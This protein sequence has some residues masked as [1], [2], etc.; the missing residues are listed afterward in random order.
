MSNIPP[1]YRKWLNALLSDQ[2][3]QIVTA[4]TQLPEKQIDAE[5]I[6]SIVLVW[7]LYEEEA[8][9]NQAIGLLQDYLDSSSIEKLPHHFEL[10][11]SVSEKLP[12]TVEDSTNLQQHHF[13]Q[14]MLIVKD[15]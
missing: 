9:Q 3:K 4:L 12:W 5:G 13:N 15:Y 10:F 14:F 7:Q 11:R 6:H 1:T 8:V 2:P